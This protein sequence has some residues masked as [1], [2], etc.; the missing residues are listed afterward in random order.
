M[1]LHFR[2][3]CFGTTLLM[4][5]I[6]VLDFLAFHPLFG[7]W[8]III[9]ECLLD[10]GKFVVVL[11]LFIMGYSMLASTMNQPF[12]YP[13]DYI[14]DPELNPNN[15]TQKELFKT[16]NSNEETNILTMFEAEIINI[17]NY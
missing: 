3:L 1:N 16:A 17:E 11:T 14:S 7:P 13:Q 2:N 12:G 5:W 8:A 9:G 15:L 4:C 6:Q 10:V